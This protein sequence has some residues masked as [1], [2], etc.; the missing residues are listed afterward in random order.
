MGVFIETP[1][2]AN[3]FLLFLH[4]EMKVFFQKLILQKSRLW[5][6]V[7]YWSLT[8]FIADSFNRGNSVLHED[9]IRSSPVY[10]LAFLGMGA[11][12]ALLLYVQTGFVLARLW[13]QGRKWACLAGILLLWFVTANLGVLIIK[14]VQPYLQVEHFTHPGFIIGPH[15]PAWTWTAWKEDLTTYLTGYFFWMVVYTL[16]W[17]ARK[18]FGQRRQLQEIR[19]QQTKAE[20]QFLKQ[21]LNPHF[22]FNTLNNL[23]GLALQNHVRMPELL[24]RLSDLLRYMIYESGAAQVSFEKEKEALLSYIQLEQLRLPPETRIDCTITADRETDIP[25]LL[26]LP[27]AE[28]IFKH[29]CFS[30]G[31]R[32]TINF[33]IAAG[34]LEIRAVNACDVSGNREE[35]FGIGLKN[36]QSRLQLLFPERHQLLCTRHNHTFEIQ[37]I[38]RLLS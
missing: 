22:L 37:I 14:L 32:A 33:C 8:L 34:R 17:F 16:A 9:P 1:E 35:I 13:E 7:L 3:P 18:F 29:G 21:Q 27:V 26:W 23:Y 6:N 19:L 10:W 4:L 36:L 2:P 24:L 12:Q 5:L 20:L 25:P 15:L 31:E 38:I 30:A 11:V 28:N